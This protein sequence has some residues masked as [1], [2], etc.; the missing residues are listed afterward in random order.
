MSFAAAFAELGGKGVPVLLVAAADHQTLHAA[1]GKQAGNLGSET[2]LGCAG[3]D[4]ELA[5]ELLALVVRYGFH[6][7]KPTFIKQLLYFGRS[8]TAA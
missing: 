1:A 4:A 2:L 5:G 8:G 7:R 3:D 6:S